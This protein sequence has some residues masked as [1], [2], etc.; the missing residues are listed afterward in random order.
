MDA[1]AV[2]THYIHGRYGFHNVRGIKFPLIITG[3]LSSTYPNQSAI[4]A[5]RSVLMF[6]EDFCPFSTLLGGI[7]KNSI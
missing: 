6:F 3:S 5:A 2:G 4:N 7:K 1:A